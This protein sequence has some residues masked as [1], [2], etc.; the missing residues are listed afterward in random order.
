MRVNERSDTKIRFD[1]R[2]L[3]ER[4]RSIGRTGFKVNSKVLSPGEIAPCYRSAMER[5]FSR[6]KYRWG[7]EYHGTGARWVQKKEF[8]KL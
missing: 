4:K 5:P 7:R 8:D 6:G 1:R 2:G 3:G